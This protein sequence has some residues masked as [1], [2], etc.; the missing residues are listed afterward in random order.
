MIGIRVAL[1]LRDA[2]VQWAERQPNDP[3]FSEAARR[4]IEL[5]LASAQLNKPP[6]KKAV[7][8]AAALAAK[9]LD[10]LKEVK[11]VAPEER[12]SRKRRL[13]KGPTEFRDIRAPKA[14]G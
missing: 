10:R 6:S 9:E 3:S 4:L 11:A 5:G 1:T 13:L 12:E 14:K 8:K 7:S 2:I